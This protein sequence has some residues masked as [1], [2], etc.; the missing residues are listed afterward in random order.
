SKTANE[1]LQTSLLYTARSVAAAVDYELGEAVA[2]AQ[3]LAR[4][5]ALFENNLDAFEAEARRALA[6]IT[7]AHVMVADLGGQ[8]LINTAQQRGQSLPIRDSAGMAAQKHA[9]EARSPYIGE[10]REGSVSQ[11]WIINIEVPI[12]K[13]GQ[14]Y[15]ALAVALKPQTF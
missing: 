1:T 10:V 4:S 12:F 13:D 11:K 14:R 5:P 2:L 15:R 7:D 3:A 6:S 8:Q 9:F